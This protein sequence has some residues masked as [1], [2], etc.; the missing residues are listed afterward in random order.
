MQ[1]PTRYDTPSWSSSPQHFNLWQGNDPTKMQ[2]CTATK[3]DI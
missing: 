2:A 1:E 3:Q